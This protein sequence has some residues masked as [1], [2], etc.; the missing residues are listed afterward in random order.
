[1]RGT[2][3][4]AHEVVAQATST[5]LILHLTDVNYGINRQTNNSKGNSY[6]RNHIHKHAYHLI[7]GSDTPQFTLIVEVSGKLWLNFIVNSNSY[8]MIQLS[9]M[10]ETAEARA[11]MATP[12]IPYL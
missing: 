6:T 2:N 10:K 3:C 4:P 9:Q 5:L 11:R 7:L 12:T 8:K 1:V